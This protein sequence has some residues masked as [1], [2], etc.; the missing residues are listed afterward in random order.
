MKDCVFGLL[1][2]VLAIPVQRIELQP[3]DRAVV[4]RVETAMNHLTVIELAEPVTLAAAGSPLFKIERQGNKVLIQPIEEGVSTNLFIW[5]NSGRFTYELVPAQSI[6]T[7]HFAIDQQAEL[8]AQ[9]AEVKPANNPA[10][11]ADEI[12]RFGNPIRNAAPRSFVQQPE[13]VIS[14]VL[15]KADRLLIR[16]TIQNF[17]THPFTTRRPEVYIV[18][19]P[20]SPVSLHAYR[21]TQ[22]EPRVAAG[23]RDEGVRLVPS[24]D[25]TFSEV[26][27]AGHHKSGILS[28]NPIEQGSTPAVLRLVFPSDSSTAPISVTVVL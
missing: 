9:P 20:R 2:L 1:A 3:A 7:T 19:S 28:L 14:D 16:Y 21:F 18:E 27:E 13:V 10:T 15:Q 24:T 6:E 5:T 22:L 4:K 11:L 23:I 12:L 17:T 25:S 26:V 8:P